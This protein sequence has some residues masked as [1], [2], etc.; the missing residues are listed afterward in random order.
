VNVTGECVRNPHQLRHGP[1]AD[2]AQV[3]HSPFSLKR[4][5]AD[6]H[7]ARPSPARGRDFRPDACSVLLRCRLTARE[8]KQSVA[9]PP[10]WARGDNDDEAP[11][12][13]PY[14]SRARYFGRGTRVRIRVSGIERDAERDAGAKGGVQASREAGGSAGGEAGNDT[15]GGDARQEV[16]RAG[17]RE[18]AD[19][20]GLARQSIWQ[21][22]RPRFLQSPLRRAFL[23][24]PAAN[25]H[26][27]D[28]PRPACAV[29]LAREVSNCQPCRP[30]PG[31]P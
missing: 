23:A 3:G 7:L 14:W 25:R 22:A 8:D 21:F 12:P 9:H 31:S 13:R 11:S 5:R 24:G 18:G 28:W 4:N 16:R 29:M 27:R 19:A 2:G 6:A 15:G 10:M 17:E 26:I 20:E 1:V 30:A